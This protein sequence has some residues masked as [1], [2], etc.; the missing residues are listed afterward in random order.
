MEAKINTALIVFLAFL[1]AIAVVTKEN[2]KKRHQI[3]IHTQKG[4]IDSLEL[5]LITRDSLIKRW[6]QHHE[7]MKIY[8]QEWDKTHTR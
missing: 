2:E 8:A 4:L 1:F 3:L 6:Q 5:E 7:R